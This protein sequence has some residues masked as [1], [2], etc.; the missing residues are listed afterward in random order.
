MTP[1]IYII[2]GPEG[3]VKTRREFAYQTLGDAKTAAK[4]HVR[5]LNRSLNARSRSELAKWEEYT[6]AEYELLEKEVHPL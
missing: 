2:W 1:R 6:I 5:A 4:N 3:P